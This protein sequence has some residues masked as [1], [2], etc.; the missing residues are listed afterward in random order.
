M[1]RTS[2]APCCARLIDGRRGE[3]NC[4]LEKR[5]HMHHRLSTAFC[6]VGS[7]LR[8][9]AVV[10]KALLV[11]APLTAQPVRAPAPPQP[12]PVAITHV[13]VI[14]VATGVKLRD[15]TVLV[16]DRHI[17]TVDTAPRV[18][19]SESTHQVDGQGRYLIP[20]LWDMHVHLLGDRLVRTNMFP[21]FIANGITG[22]RD[23]WGDC[24]SICAADEAD[25][26][27]PVPAAVLQRWKRDINSGAL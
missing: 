3:R 18:R 9:S 19:V 25:N 7:H 4:L 13:T 26:F 21:L 10:V 12:D 22:V 8:A 2:P 5:R 23:M 14:D 20:G 17:A 27:N 1:R 16:R 15:R 24:D 11:S 6:T